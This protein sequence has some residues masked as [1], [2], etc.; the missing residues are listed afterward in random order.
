MADRALRHSGELLAAVAASGQ[1]PGIIDQVETPGRLVY[2]KSWIRDQAGCSS[3]MSGSGGLRGSRGQDGTLP[4]IAPRS[5][6]AATFDSLFRHFK[7]T[8]M[9]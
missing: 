1:R 5:A 9:G 3:A 8:Y 6:K 4:P 7:C 2:P